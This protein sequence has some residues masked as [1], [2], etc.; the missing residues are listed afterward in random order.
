MSLHI[1]TV[2]TK[3]DV[4]YLPNL[5]KG[6][7]REGVTLNILGLGQKWTGF[8]MKYNLLREFI[9]TLPKTD[10]IIFVDGYDV[11]LLNLDNIVSKFKSFKKPIV[12]SS[13]NQNVD[14]LLSYFK[15]RIFYGA[16]NTGCYMGYVWGFEKFFEFYCSEFDCMDN[17]LD[18]QRTMGWLLYHSKNK[19]KVQNLI[20]IDTD[21]KIFYTIEFKFQD[22]DI[23]IKGTPNFVHG[24]GNTNM[25][26]LVEKYK[27]QSL[28]TDKRK[29]YM[30][31][32]QLNNKYSKFF[33]PELVILITTII[34]IILIVNSVLVLRK[35]QR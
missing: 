26:S 3:Y 12:V 2:A 33:I 11:L 31:I 9:K 28:P 1:I 20:A 19:N 14:F 5:E 32:S 34:I 23:E 6:C 7:I 21:M 25:D 29:E 10:I 16:Q 15:N 17:S 35:N 30:S 13:E 18:D 22:R 24:P 27:L 8:A 4:G